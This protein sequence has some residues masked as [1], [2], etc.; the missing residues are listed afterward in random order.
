MPGLSAVETGDWPLGLD[1]QLLSFGRFFV[2]VLLPMSDAL[3]DI[4]VLTL[5]L[6]VHLWRPLD[7]QI[8]V[9]DCTLRQASAR[10]RFFGACLVD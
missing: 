3:I 6:M 9:S 7:T 8:L 1:P 5:Q 10:P 4:D 2:C